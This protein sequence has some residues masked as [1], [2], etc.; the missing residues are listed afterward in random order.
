VLRWLLRHTIESFERKW[1]YDA[2][3]L[4]EIVDLSPLAA[5]KFSLATSLGRYR[6]DVPPAALFAAGITAVRSEDCGPCTQLGIAMAEQQ[7]VRP[8]ILR[9]LLKDDVAAMPE[10][11]ALAWR[12]TRATLAHDAAADDYRVEI[13]RRWG[14]RAVVTLA[15]AITTA[16]MYPTVKYAMG[17]G[18]ICSRVVVNGAPVTIDRG[19][20]SRE[21][22]LTRGQSHASR[23]S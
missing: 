14:P 5:W 6:R 18:K 16:R 23:A 10:E 7:G 13:V 11:V 15:F 2:S 12:F 17:H 4:K 20:T 8:E 19:V 1:N 21:W 9:A 3:Y 22:P